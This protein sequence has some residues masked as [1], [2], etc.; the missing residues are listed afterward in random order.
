MQTRSSTTAFAPRHRDFA[1]EVGSAV[2]WFGAQIH[3]LGA[4]WAARQRAVRELERLS[5]LTDYELRDMGIS[6]SDFPAIM[7]GTYRRF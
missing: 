3:R 6:R 7:A 1:S 2:V 4:A 5:L